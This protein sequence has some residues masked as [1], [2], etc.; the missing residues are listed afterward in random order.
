MKLTEDDMEIVD[1]Y[2]LGKLN[3]DALIDFEQ[4]LKEEEGF[5]EEVEEMHVLILAAKQSSL[6]DKMKMLQQEE[7][8]ID[9]VG[10]MEDSESNNAK[11]DK[12]KVRRLPWVRILSIA[13]SVLVIG[14]IGVWWSGERDNSIEL[15]NITLPESPYKGLGGENKIEQQDDSGKRGFEL[16]ELGKRLI[17]KK[18]E[19]YKKAF[20]QASQELEQAYENT[21]DSTYLI[22]SL[23]SAKASNDIARYNQLSAKYNLKLDD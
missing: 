7:L 6:E 1:A 23:Y 18:D 16:Y 9:D 14:V 17:E 5:A 3:G 12:G 8:K 20:K 15:S 13:A 21:A 11:S 2:L 10:L 4:R 22:F 19:Q